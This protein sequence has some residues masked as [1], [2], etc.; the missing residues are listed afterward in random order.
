MIC[1]GALFLRLNGVAFGAPSPDK[2]PHI[3][4][5]WPM[6]LHLGVVLAA[7]IFIPVALAQWFQH[8]AKL[9]G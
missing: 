9:L 4:P 2:S 1:L 7:G 6:L 8:V 5:V 3:G